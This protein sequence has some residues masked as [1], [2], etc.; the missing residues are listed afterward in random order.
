M[1]GRDLFALKISE[2][3]QITTFR[4]LFL[5]NTWNVVGL[6]ETHWEGMFLQLGSR[7][8]QSALVKM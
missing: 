6:I 2:A 5:P 3:C 8:W 1:V 4:K 7:L